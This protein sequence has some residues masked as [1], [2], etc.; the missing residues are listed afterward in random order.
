MRLPAL[1]SDFAKQGVSHVA[2]QREGGCLP[3]VALAEVGIEGSPQGIPKQSVAPIQAAPS[4]HPTQLRCYG[5][6]GILERGQSGDGG[7]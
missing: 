7:I 6:S 5:H 2:R 1:R 4:I 3:A